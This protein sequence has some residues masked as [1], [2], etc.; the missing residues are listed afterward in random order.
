AVLVAGPAHGTL[1]LAANGGFDYTPTAGYT[2]AD[3]FTYKNSDGV[4]N[5][6]TAT[7]NLTVGAGFTYTPVADNPAGVAAGTL[8]ATSNHDLL[9]I[10]PLGTAGGII[11]SFLAASDAAGF[12]PY[13]ALQQAAAVAALTLWAETAGIGIAAAAAGEAGNL[14]FGNSTG[15]GYAEF[16]DNAAGNGGTIWTNPDFG[17]TANPSSGSYGFLTLLHETGHALGLGHP[18]DAS[19]TQLDSVMAYRAPDAIGVDWWNAQGHWV[20]PQTPMVDDIATLQ[21]VYGADTTTRAGDTVYCFHATA[22]NDVFDFTANAD[23]VLTIYDAGGNDTLDLSG[24][25]TP[26]VIGLT[27]GATSSANGMTHNIGIALGTIIETAI[28]GSGDDTIKGTARAETLIGG[29]G[30]DTLVGGGGDDTLTGG[31]GDDTISVPDLAFL[32]VD[33]GGGTDKLVLL[34]SGQTF[35]FTTLADSKVTSI[36]TIDITGS[37]N[38]TVKIGGLD[39]MNMSDSFNFAFTA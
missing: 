27:P 30:N 3:S 20:D 38:N 21:G 15:H 39:V 36:E 26:S 19:V 25:D 17:V 31:A 8:A 33:G 12:S 34:G 7:V 4:L 11:Y 18:T 28:G 5:S 10:A 22:G 16:V 37:G 6:G 24:Y 9:P 2:G 29:A 14:Q 23:P 1:A 13:S 35:D 32:S